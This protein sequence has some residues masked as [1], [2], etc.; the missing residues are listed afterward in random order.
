MPDNISDKELWLK[1]WISF[2]DDMFNKEKEIKYNMESFLKAREEQ[3]RNLLEDIS[4]FYKKSYEEAKKDADNQAVNVSRLEAKIERLEKA[5][6]KHGGHTDECDIW[7]CTCGLV[8][9]APDN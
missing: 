4:A 5:I 2:T 7:P 8:E 3:V 1:D 9:F 6:K